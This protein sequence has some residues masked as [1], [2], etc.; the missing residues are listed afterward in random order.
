MTQGDAAGRVRQVD[1]R[2]LFAVLAGLPIALVVEAPARALEFT[3]DLITHANGK[4]HVSNLYYRDDRWRMEHQ[5]IGPVNVTIVRKD[6]QV[7]WLL[8][9]RF[10]HFK[11]VPYD[12]SHAPKVQETHD[13]EISRRV[14]GMNT[15]DGHPTTRYE[16]HVT[17][18]EA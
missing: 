5:D 18:G 16:V 9:S 11:E 12:A 14:I 17:E 8:I 10:K 1:G 6:K 15:L 3:A 4:T 2:M 13:A 7:T